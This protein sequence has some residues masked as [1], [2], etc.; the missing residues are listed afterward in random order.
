MKALVL[1]SGG[2]D[3]TTCLYLAKKEYDEVHTITVDY[4]Q[5]HRA[6][7]GAACCIATIAA[8]DSHE[9]I[10]VDGGVLKSNSP[11]T[12]DS[13]LEQYENNTHM[14][15]VIGNRVEKT[16]VPMRNT[17]LLT[18]AAN[19]AIELRC[20]VI[21]IGACSDDSANYPDCSVEFISAM[22]AVINKSIGEYS[23][24]TIKTPLIYLNKKSVC[25]LANTLSGCMTALAYSHTS[26]DGKY[27]PVDMN[28]ANVLRAK[29]F[30]DADLPDPLVVRAWV[31]GLMPLPNTENYCSRGAPNQLV[32]KTAQTLKNYGCIYNV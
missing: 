26:Y 8:V 20:D 14:G 1:L 22:Q 23:R 13:E 21:V 15:Q 18:I 6:E 16:F 24:L 3:S 30:E 17:L 2:Q 7:I 4:N 5:R 11:L 29:G 12:S 32:L 25:L 10:V 9:V 31:E 19:R 27:P 28:H